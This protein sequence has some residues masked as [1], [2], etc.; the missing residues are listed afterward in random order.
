MLQWS[1]DKS[2]WHGNGKQMAGEW[3]LEYVEMVQTAEQERGD[4]L[5]NRLL[6]LYDSYQCNNC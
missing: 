1:I 3:Y 4:L 2:R 5:I 6:Q